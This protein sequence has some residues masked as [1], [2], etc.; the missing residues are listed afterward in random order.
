MM[1]WRAGQELYL[2]ETSVE[3]GLEVQVNT[4]VKDHA[5]YARGWV[6][7]WRQL[8]GKRRLGKGMAGFRRNNIPI[9]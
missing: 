6:V 3:K 8:G 1:A 7:S 9:L 2:G 5:H 4:R